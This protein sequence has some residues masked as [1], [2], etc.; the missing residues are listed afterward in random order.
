MPPKG[1]KP[2]GKAKGKGKGKAKAKAAA[3]AAAAAVV[4]STAGEATALAPGEVAE[5]G[6]EGVAAEGG[7]DLVGG[8]AIVPVAKAK[9]SGL[10]AI[11][12][13][14]FAS[15]GDRPVEEAMAEAKAKLQKE[16]AMMETARD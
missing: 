3:A 2:K 9:S 4:A 10:S 16:D 15:L 1:P 11:R 5:V 14:V 8:G 7:D 13:Q 12:K 6:A